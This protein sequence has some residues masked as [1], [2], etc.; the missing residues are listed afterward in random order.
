MA[1]HKHTLAHPIKGVSG[2]MIT[3]VT[4]RDNPKVGDYL[5]ASRYSG[6]NATDTVEGAYL[7]CALTGLEPSEFDDLD[8]V[9]FQALLDLSKVGQDTPDPKE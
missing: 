3:E 4:I 8:M 2:D 5:R 7:V 6:S 1:E 9:D